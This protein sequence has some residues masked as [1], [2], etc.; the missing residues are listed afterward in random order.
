MRWYKKARKWKDN[1]PGGRADKKKPSDFNKRDLS[2]GTQIEYEH[3]NDPAIAKEISM[4]HL[5]E[6]PDYYDG[7]KGLPAMER[8]L[9]KKKPARCGRYRGGLQR[10][11]I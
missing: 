7:K 10:N 2:R 9:E 6:L 8:K 3:T 1:I 4:D 5:E 11:K